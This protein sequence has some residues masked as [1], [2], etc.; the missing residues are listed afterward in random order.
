MNREDR[1]RSTLND[2]LYIARGYGKGQEGGTAR[3]GGA[4]ISFYHKMHGLKSPPELTGS[5]ECVRRINL[6]LNLVDHPSS[7]VGK[8]GKVW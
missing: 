5:P 1:C 3:S 6:A 4:A 8:L 2:K 7:L